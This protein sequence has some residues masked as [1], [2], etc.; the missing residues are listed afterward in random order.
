M[1][2]STPLSFLFATL[3]FIGR[4]VIISGDGAAGVARHQAM[5]ASV[6]YEKCLSRMTLWLL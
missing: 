6:I 1:Q 3:L 4:R 5:R 2:Q